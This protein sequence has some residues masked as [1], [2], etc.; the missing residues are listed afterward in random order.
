ML[1]VLDS[2]M[3]I[4]SPHQDLYSFRSYLLSVSPKEAAVRLLKVRAETRTVKIGWVN[5][6]STVLLWS[7]S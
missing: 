7:G 3:N 4:F 6:H 1:L 5:I 2:R